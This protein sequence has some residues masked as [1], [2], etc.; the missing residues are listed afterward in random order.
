MKRAGQLSGGVTKS[1][2]RPLPKV[3]NHSSIP[4]LS[5]FPKLCP[6]REAFVS[7][8]LEVFRIR[9]PI[10]HVWPRHIPPLPAYLS[11]E[12]RGYS[13][14]PEI[15]T[16][17]LEFPRDVR[18]GRAQ[19]RLRLGNISHGERKREPS[20][21]RFSGSPLGNKRALAPISRLGPAQ[22]MAIYQ[23]ASF[24]FVD[25]CPYNCRISHSHS[26]VIVLPSRHSSYTQFSAASRSECR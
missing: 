4:L 9:N 2:V 17:N 16:K 23:G 24:V 18:S 14:K 11:A 7:C 3:R 5:L 15:D 26:V 1:G 20:T 8:Q 25:L 22:Q 6:L 10:R 13:A 21:A 12:N 19:W